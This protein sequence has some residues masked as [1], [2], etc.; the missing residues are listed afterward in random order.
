MLLAAFQ[1]LVS[2]FL[3]QKTKTESLRQSC[4]KVRAQEKT[5][6]EG[7]HLLGYSSRTAVEIWKV[8]C[9]TA[10]L[11]SSGKLDGKSQTKSVTSLLVSCI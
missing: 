9:F 4:V 6:V 5:M 7:N 2:D 11:L 1:V 3:R 10:G 8:L